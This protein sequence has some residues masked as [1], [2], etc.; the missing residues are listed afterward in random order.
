MFDLIANRWSAPEREK[1]DG[2]LCPFEMQSKTIRK[3]FQYRTENVSF[4]S[5]CE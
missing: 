2:A 1:G 5:V 3:Y 4:S